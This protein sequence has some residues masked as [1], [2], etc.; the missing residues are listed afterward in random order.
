MRRWEKIVRKKSEKEKYLK[1][2]EK[3][4][5]RLGLKLSYVILKDKEEKNNE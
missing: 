1:K 3:K 2:Q 5:K 4:A